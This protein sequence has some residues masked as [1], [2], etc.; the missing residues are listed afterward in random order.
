VESKST[1]PAE[2]L[3]QED[4]GADDGF[5]LTGIGQSTYTLEY[6]ARPSEF[7]MLAVPEEAP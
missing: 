2:G 6:E 1:S 3:G 7:E 4:D 5:P